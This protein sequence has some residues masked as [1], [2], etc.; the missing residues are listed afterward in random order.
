MVYFPLFAFGLYV[1]LYLKWISCRQ[2]I[3]GLWVLIHS[4]NLWLLLGALRPLTFKMII[5]IVGVNAL[6][7]FSDFCLLF[8]CL[9]WLSILHGYAFS[10]LLAC[11]LYFFFSFLVIAREFVIELYN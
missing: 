4:D 10:P 11:Q 7:F 3:V 1:S 5:D 2:Y 6:I 8:F 9:L